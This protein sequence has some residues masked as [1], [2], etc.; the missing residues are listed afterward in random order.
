MTVAA[1]IDLEAEEEVI[2]I[3]WSAVVAENN[4]NYVYKL[5]GGQAVRHPVVI[6]ARSGDEIAVAQGL[7]AGDSIIVDLQRVKPGTRIRPVSALA[8]PVG[9]AR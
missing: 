9:N 3:P 5:F 8:N 6:G 7:N 2:L 1:A 4:S